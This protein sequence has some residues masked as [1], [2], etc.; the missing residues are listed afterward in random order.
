MTTRAAKSAFLPRRH[1]LLALVA[2]LAVIPP[3]AAQK[4]VPGARPGAGAKAEAPAPNF[5]I[6]V[7]PK[8]WR[9]LPGGLRTLGYVAHKDGTAVLVIE[10]EQLQIA[11]NSD[12]IDG[13]FADLELADLKEREAGGSAFTSQIAQVGRRRMVMV[14]YQRRG[15]VEHVRVY[16]VVQGRTLYRLVCVAP[17]AQFARY[18]PIFQVMSASFTA[19]DAAR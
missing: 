9:L 12:E 3:V 13:N 4:P 19:L 2:S 11:L 8:D 1:L 14:D 7:P 16:V 15:G 6:D 10:S 17:A 18:S 5:L